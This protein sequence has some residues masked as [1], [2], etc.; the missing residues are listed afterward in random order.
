M[1]RLFLSL[2]RMSVQTG[3]VILAVLAGRIL[4]RKAPKRWSYLLWTAV[5]FRMLCPFGIQSPFSLLQILPGPFRNQPTEAARL[6]S[7]GTPAAGGIP[8]APVPADPV[9]QVHPLV[10]ETAGSAAEPASLLLRIGMVLWIV[11]MAVLLTA[12]AVQYLQLRRRLIGAIRTEDGVW[13]SDRI[14]SPI[15]T[16]LF[17]PEI[18]LPPDLTGE[19][20]TVVLAHERFHIRHLDHAVRLLQYCLLCVYWFNPLVWLGY[21]LMGRDMELRCDEAV[22]TKQD[23]GGY[24]RALLQV[25]AGGRFPGPVPL[26]FGESDVKVRI[27]HALDWRRPKTWITVLALLFCAAL[28]AVCVTDPVRQLCFSEIL[29]FSPEQ[30]QKLEAVVIIDRMEGY[31]GLD[32]QG[33]EAQAFLSGL[34]DLSCRRKLRYQPDFSNVEYAVKMMVQGPDGTQISLSFIDGTLNCERGQDR[35]SYRLD[36]AVTEQL[37][38][39]IERG[40]LAV[41]AA[42]PQLTLRK[43]L[44][45]AEEKGSAL[46]W[47]DFEVYPHEDVGSGLVIWSIPLEETLTLLIGGA[48]TQAEPMYIRLCAAE[49]Y[50]DFADLLT[51]DPAAFARQHRSYHFDL[52][53]GW[54]RTDA[55]VLSFITAHC[56]LDGMKLTGGSYMDILVSGTEGRKR[57]QVWTEDGSRYDAYA[58]GEWKEH[59]SWTSNYRRVGPEMRVKQI[60]ITPAS[61]D[62]YAGYTDQR[63]IPVP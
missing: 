23:G 29:G 14:A 4:L 38:W 8:A 60:L 57:F 53:S 35:R 9:Y 12:A 5:L 49:N 63:G 25:A 2:L 31:S 43:L 50:A 33:E 32:L 1:E 40:V 56:S 59:R 42:S 22:M 52:S 13:E 55:Q 28:A 39:Q 24:S 30:V 27:K 15:V 6:V 20:R 44:S 62:P 19:I 48:T 54:L 11:G 17:R 18:Y 16:G 26:A 10:P 3:V 46:T 41:E 36:S 45:L 37:S 61:A 51:G 58:I 34:T 21:R 7:S 47:A